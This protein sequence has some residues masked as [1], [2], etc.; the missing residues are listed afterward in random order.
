[1]S[2][3]LAQSSQ[4][5]L[6]NYFSQGQEEVVERKDIIDEKQPDDFVEPRVTEQSLDEAQLPVNI[7]DECEKL[8]EE[9]V[10][11]DSLR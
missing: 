3:E 6:H 8:G 9:E 11:L 1:L 5:S 4:N 7:E 10:R 2:K